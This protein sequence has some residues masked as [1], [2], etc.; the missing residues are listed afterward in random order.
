[1]SNHKLGQDY[2]NNLNGLMNM[3]KSQVNLKR[4]TRLID[5]L[6]FIFYFFYYPLH[7]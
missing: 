1:M 2:S 7:C 6:F 3:A 5:F 4:Y